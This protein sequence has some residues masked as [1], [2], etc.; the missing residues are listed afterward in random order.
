MQL[1]DPCLSESMH[2]QIRT[3]PCSTRTESVSGLTGSV[4]QCWNSGPS[5]E[6]QTPRA[7]LGSRT[8]SK[9]QHDSI[10]RLVTRRIY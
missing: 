3:T 10:N 2:K 9:R 7:G 8:A 1:R 6:V 4:I 5:S